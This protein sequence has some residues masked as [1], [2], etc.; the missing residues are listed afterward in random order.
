MNKNLELMETTL[1]E[2]VTTIKSPT[3]LTVLCGVCEKKPW[4]H[5]DFMNITTVGVCTRCLQRDHLHG[6][7][8]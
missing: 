7:D 5:Q 2:M 6:E 4:D 1:K 8:H 3:N